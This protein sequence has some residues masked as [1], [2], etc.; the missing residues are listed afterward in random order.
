MDAAPLA[1]LRRRELERLPQAAEPVSAIAGE[2]TRDW[3]AAAHI[4]GCDS[5]FSVQDVGQMTR[6]R[7]RHGQREDEGQRRAG[8]GWELEAN[9]AAAAAALLPAGSPQ[10]LRRTSFEDRL[11]NS[12]KHARALDL[13]LQLLGRRKRP[14]W[15]LLGAA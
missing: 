9:A 6:S 12:P 13:R 15:Q 10:R 3:E 5:V 1:T 2:G 7:A 11:S 4:V 14:L 8:A